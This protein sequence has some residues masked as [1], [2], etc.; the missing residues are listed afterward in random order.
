MDCKEIKRSA[1]L[2]VDNEL[3]ARESQSWESHLAHCD[4]CR[5]VIESHR[6]LSKAVRSQ[7]TYHRAP[8]KLSEKIARILDPGILP[9][10]ALYGVSG[11]FAGAVAC[12]LVAFAFLP[13]HAGNLEEQL[14]S[15]HVRALMVNHLTDVASTDQHTVKPWFDGKLDFAPPVADFTEKGFPLMGGRMD[16]IDRRPVAALAYRHRLHV[17]NVFIWPSAGPDRSLQAESLRG[18]NLVH[19]NRAG[20]A[21]W[22]VSDLNADELEQLAKLLD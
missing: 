19:W 22:A 8:P 2:F 9:P 15:S 6:S 3:D 20:L 10:P 14:V 1:A 13:R 16:Y 12:A 18:Y 21:L 17:I 4:E 7:A 11:F 5:A